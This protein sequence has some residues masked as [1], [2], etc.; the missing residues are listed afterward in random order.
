[1]GVDRLVLCLLDLKRLDQAMVL[2][3]YQRI[4]SC[5]AHLYGL[6]RFKRPICRPLR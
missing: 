4:E 6:A 2:L 5:V 1:M 3:V